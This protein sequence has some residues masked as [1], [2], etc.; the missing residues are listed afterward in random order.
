M[1]SSGFVQAVFV[2]YSTSTTI[3]LLSIDANIKLIVFFPITATFVMQSIQLNEPIQ[4]NTSRR[5]C[6]LAYFIAQLVKSIR[7]AQLFLKCAVHGKQANSV[8]VDRI[9]LENEWIA[10]NNILRTNNRNELLFS[11]THI[12]T[13][14]LLS[15]SH[16][17]YIFTQKF[18]EFQEWWC[19]NDR[20]GNM[21]EWNLIAFVSILQWGQILLNCV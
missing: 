2:N 9:D 18:I 14:R 21:C 15:H 16:V 8:H 13:E 4:N 7:H 10:V 20:P 12:F 1:S 19:K 5:Q 6:S 11:H 17:T 3:R